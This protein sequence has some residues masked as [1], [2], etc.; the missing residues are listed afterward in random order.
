MTTEAA[1]LVYV[2]DTMPG[3]TR[4]RG[5]H[6]WLYRR[7]D[8]SVIT[9]PGERAWIDAIW[10]PPAWTDVWISPTPNG[11]ILA[12]GRDARHRKQYRYHPRWRE[13]RDR[14]KYHRMGEFGR[15]LPGLRRRIDEDLD[16]PGLP[17]EKVL[18]AVIRLMDQTLVRIGNEQYARQ[19][20]SYGLT[21]LRHDHVRFA[22][23]ATVLFEFRAKSGK[24]QRVLLSDPR[25][26]AI[27][28]ACHELPG[29]ELFQYLDDDGKIVDVGSAEVNAYLRA[30]TKAIFTAKD[31]RTWGGSVT[32]AEG[33]AGLGPPRTVTE[34]KRKINAAIDAAAERL[35][36]TRAVCRR[37]YV[38]PRVPESYMDGTL[39]DAFHRARKRSRLSH[40][41]SA[42]LLLA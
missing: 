4:E 1:G 35:N 7:P 5:K 39:D 18:G 40:G 10:I 33:L 16:L 11:H 8:G 20:Q 36:N 15:A 19:N 12:T 32:A 37:S 13:V 34:A 25:L 42:M 28:H 17:R 27:V 24:R 38:N 6:G 30:V 2:T 21:T 23:P 3:I 29:Q 14:T 26:A 22:D 31:F 9:D 41:E